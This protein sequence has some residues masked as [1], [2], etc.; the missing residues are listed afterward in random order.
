MPGPWTAKGG[1]AAPVGYATYRLVVY[2]DTDAPLV[3]YIDS[4]PSAYRMW[5]NEKLVSH[6]GQVGRS[7]RE[8]KRGIVPILSEIF[9]LSEKTEIIVQVSNFHAAEGGLITS[10]ELGERNLIQRRFQFYWV[11]VA[12]ML[13]AVLMMGFYHLAL[14]LFRRKERSNLY[15]SMYCGLWG[16]NFT[17]S[18]VSIWTVQ[19]LFPETPLEVFRRIDHVTLFGSVPIALMFFHALYPKEVSPSAVRISQVFFAAACLE[20]IVAPI[21]LA[22]TMLLYMIAPIIA[23]LLYGFRAVLRAAVQKRTG[24]RLIFTGYV[25]MGGAALNDMLLAW[26]VVNSYYLVLF[27][28]FFFLLFQSFAVSLRFSHA[29]TSAEH[30][31]L[32]LEEKNI[33][34]SR[35]DAVKDEFLANTSHELRTPLHG[36]A[37]I[38]ESL[39]SGAFGRLPQEAQE[40]MELIVSVAERLI[41][42]INDILDFS[43]LKHKDIT[44]RMR[45]VDLRTLAQTVL[46]VSKHSTKGKQISLQLEMPPELPLVSADE[47]RLQQILFNLVGNSIKFTPKG[48]VRISA[49]VLDE[50]V[51]ICVNDSGIGIP[52]AE[53][54]RIFDSFERGDRAGAEDIGAGIGL[55]VTRQLV[56]LHGGTIRVKSEPEQGAAFFF[57][58]DIAEGRPKTTERKYSKKAVSIDKAVQSESLEDAALVLAVDDE[59]V[60][61]QVLVNHLNQD[62][63]AVET[64]RDGRTGLAFIEERD[65][66][67]LVL[68]DINMPG[69]D[70]LEVCRRIRAVYSAAELPVILLTAR[71]RIEDLTAGFEAGANDYLTKPF[72]RGELLSRVR[73]HL[74]LKQAYEELADRM[75]MEV[76]LEKRRHSEEKAL[77]SVRQERLEKLRYQFAPHFLFNA[78]NSIRASILDN[79][80]AA[81]EMISSLAELNRVSIARR[82]VTT[83][84]LEQDLETIRLYMALEQARYGSYLSFSVDI[85]PETQ[86][87]QVPCFVFQPLVENA[88]KYGKQTRHDALQIVIST[89]KKQDDIFLCVKNTG[90]WVPPEEP[91]STHSTGFGLAHLRE[92]LKLYYAEKASLKHVEKDGWVE[93]TVQLPRKSG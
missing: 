2:T 52:Q 28:I 18:A 10:V 83:V 92:R 79:P 31:S 89:A 27:G 46:E 64:T 25:I 24:A 13:G 15:L 82:S 1:K 62:G 75:I 59:V 39:I 19:Y 93:V 53:Q 85:D 91:R 9:F 87:A 50:Q 65:D 80:M 41:F 4:I 76:E 84:T 12:C 48:F 14:F 43:R 45:P 74:K 7:L 57:N 78:L 17:V 21:W 60:N 38:A 11:S 51:E 88:I 37:G 40:N 56:Q 29:F 81:R 35:M 26:G 32:A 67:D 3:L 70:G 68:L 61:L 47:D 69:M 23:A 77:L 73:L 5:V 33:A 34:L 6:A 71:T 72:T 20:A 16:I 55:S 36:I 63:I 86:M 49:R 22:E 66:C 42:L 30:L 44:L 58:L 8:E 54:T 90:R